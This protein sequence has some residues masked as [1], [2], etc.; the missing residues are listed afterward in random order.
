MYIV[1]Q[2]FTGVSQGDEIL[3]ADSHTIKFELQQ[4]AANII[5]AE[6]KL[7][8]D[9]TY[10]SIGIFNVGD[11]SMSTEVNAEGLYELDIENL[12]SVRFRVSAFISGDIKIISKVVN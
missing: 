2:T 7:T 8:S 12:H 6:G 3:V 1:E 5:T 10:A 4:T 9:G 11:I